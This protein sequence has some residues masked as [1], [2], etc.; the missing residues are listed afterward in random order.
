[1]LL[2]LAIRD[3]AIIDETRIPF[4]EGLNALTGET[5]AGKSILIDALG[6][7]LGERVS[8]E[9]VRTGA[10]AAHVEA[11][12]DVGDELARPEFPAVLGEFGIEPDDGVLILARE[13]G[14]TGRGGAR[15]NGRA[16]TA[17]TLARIGALLVDIHGQSDHLS[18]LRPSEQL[19]V[20][21]RFAGLTARRAALAGVVAEWRE[22]RTRLADAT[23]NA[24]ER[25]Q[26]ADLLRFLVEEISTANLRSGAPGR[27]RPSPGTRAPRRP[28]PPAGTPPPP[29]ARTAP[30][31]SG[32]DWRC[33]QPSAPPA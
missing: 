19:E 20:L 32:P 17:G 1:M 16:V 8:S 9:M 18:L 31:P 23:A 13:I 5:G 14:A 28:H 3:F 4:R 30:P 11:V 33:P 6:A 2:E 24:R 26:R 29:A 15:S 25:A 27:P 7:V 10:K 22:T 21:D 12:F